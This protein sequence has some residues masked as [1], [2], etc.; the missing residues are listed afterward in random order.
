MKID[1]FE[2]IKDIVPVFGMG[3]AAFVLYLA[4]R[5]KQLKNKEKIALI[6]KGLDPSL[7]YPNV[8]IPIGFIRRSL[9]MFNGFTRFAAAAV[10]WFLERKRAA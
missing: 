4:Y 7:L 1:M 6:E 10:A 2:I 5:E 3:F 8:R 9:M